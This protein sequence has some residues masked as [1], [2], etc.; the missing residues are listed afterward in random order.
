MCPLCVTEGLNRILN[1]D[2][3]L[4]TL[5]LKGALRTKCPPPSINLVM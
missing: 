5:K 2:K 3:P 1:T 4:S